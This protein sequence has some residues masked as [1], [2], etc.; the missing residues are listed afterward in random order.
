MG[1]ELVEQRNEAEGLGSHLRV[2]EV[3]PGCEH[4]LSDAPRGGVKAQC[5]TISFLDSP[6]H[7]P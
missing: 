1:T 4:V 5:G 2:T 6:C 3:V 7:R